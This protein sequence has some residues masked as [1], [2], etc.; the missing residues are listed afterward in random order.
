MFAEESKWNQCDE[1]KIL[2]LGE[3]V[4]SEFTESQGE[5]L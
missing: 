1:L 2:L 5:E 3:P 4:R